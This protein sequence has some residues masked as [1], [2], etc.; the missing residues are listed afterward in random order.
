[1]DGVTPKKQKIGS[2]MLT[3][4]C[5][6][7]SGVQNHFKVFQSEPNSFQLDLVSFSGEFFW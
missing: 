4:L 7:D 2:N 6:S 3:Y 5:V 1:M